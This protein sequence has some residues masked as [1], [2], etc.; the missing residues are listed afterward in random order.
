MG[1]R[2]TSSKHGI[3]KK[4]PSI[5]NIL[6]QFVVEELGLSRFLVT[7]DQDLSNTNRA[8]AV[9]ETLLHSLTSSHDR[10][11]ANLALEHETIVS[12]TNRR[13]DSVLNDRQMVKT[14]LN[15]QSND[16]IGIEDEVCALRLF[17]TD[18][19][20]HSQLHGTS[21]QLGK[22]TYDSRAMS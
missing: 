10:H 8:A 7:L 11:A 9:T 14:F 12:A 17:A 3:Q 21:A 19:P 1:G 5:R 15:K 16:S 13:S 18:H 20:G 4:H 6:G 22:W 2:R